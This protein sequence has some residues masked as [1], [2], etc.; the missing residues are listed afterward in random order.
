MGRR[1]RRN[2]PTHQRWRSSLDQRAKWHTSRPGAHLFLGSY[3][4]LGSGFW[5]DHH[6]VWPRGSAKARAVDIAQSNN[7]PS[8]I[9][10]L[11][12]NGLGVAPDSYISRLWRLERRALI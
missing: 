9:E 2:C 3:A 12:A 7:Y 6:F 1:R 4:W 10:R 8:A 11:W 5:R